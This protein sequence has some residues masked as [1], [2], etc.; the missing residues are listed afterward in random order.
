MA[1][2]TEKSNNAEVSKIL[3]ENKLTT[4]ASVINSVVGVLFIGIGLATTYTLWKIVGE[5]GLRKGYDSAFELKNRD[6]VLF[7][8]EGVVFSEVAGDVTKLDQRIKSSI[9]EYWDIVEGIIKDESQIQKNVWCH[10]PTTYHLS[11]NPIVRFIWGVHMALHEMLDTSKKD[12]KKRVKDGKNVVLETWG[13]SGLNSD[14]WSQE[15]KNKTAEKWN[16]MF[17]VDLV[18]AYLNATLKLRANPRITIITEDEYKLWQEDPI[19]NPIPFV[20]FQLND[21]DIGI[22]PSELI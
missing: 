7:V 9:E 3:L 21:A 14:I 5:R 2:T 20:N 15:N 4:Q 1:S 11:E 19:A 12:V 22:K 10:V 16:T 13:Q 17:K 18:N 6:N 8:G